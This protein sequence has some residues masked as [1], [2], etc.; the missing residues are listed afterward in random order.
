MDGF[1]AN[2]AGNKF[3]FLRT[4]HWNERSKLMNRRKSGARADFV[5]KLRIPWFSVVS[6]FLVKVS[7]WRQS[8]SNLVRTYILC[9]NIRIFAFK[10]S[11][12]GSVYLQK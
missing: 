5:Y 11:V 7:N 8:H 10:S 1:Y 4:T 6:H 9:L 2:E 12:F 3:R